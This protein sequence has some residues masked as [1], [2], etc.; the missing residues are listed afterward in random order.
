M[1]LPFVAFEAALK[2]AAV[3]ALGIMISIAGAGFATGPAAAEAEA[4]GQMP[5]ARGKLP[6]AQ[7]LPGSAQRGEAGPNAKGPGTGQPNGEE[8]GRSG[9][10]YRRGPLELIV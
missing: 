1:A 2:W 5:G 9:C 4:G 8:Q 3:A 10:P 6:N 7:P